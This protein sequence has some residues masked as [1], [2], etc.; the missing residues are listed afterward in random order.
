MFGNDRHVGFRLSC[1]GLPGGLDNT[2]E[3][4][5]T[6]VGMPGKFV[7]AS[8]GEA[9]DERFACRFRTPKH[10]LSLFGCHPRNHFFGVDVWSPVQGS[11]RPA[12]AT[13]NPLNGPCKQGRL[14]AVS[15]PRSRLA[16]PGSMPPSRLRTANPCRI[17][18]DAACSILIPTFPVRPD[19]GS[20]RVNAQLTPP[21]S[22]G[23]GSGKVIESGTDFG[24]K[25]KKREAAL[26]TGERGLVWSL[27]P[28]R[29]TP[30]GATDRLQDI[31]GD[32]RGDV[33]GNI[34]WNVSRN[35][36]PSSPARHQA[37]ARTGDRPRTGR[38]GQSAP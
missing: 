32:V 36:C 31:G 29:L 37:C 11:W 35:G 6:R 38:P 24:E 33:R 2:R 5:V 19:Q 23:A 26:S 22:D 21:S 14:Q 12:P 25:S 7:P 34:C 3:S 16:R 27:R 18:P 10:S 17:V 20:R 30:S 13:E 28:G 15:W 1:A 8:T 4:F 9:G